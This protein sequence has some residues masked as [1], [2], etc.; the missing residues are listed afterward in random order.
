MSIKKKLANKFFFRYFELMEN[1]KAPAAEAPKPAAQTGPDRAERRRQERAQNEKPAPKPQAAQRQKVPEHVMKFI[2]AWCYNMSEANKAEYII[3]LAGD[4][5]NL[6]S[7][8]QVLIKER[9][10]NKSRIVRPH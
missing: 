6:A 9:K 1:N 8:V 5:A 7:M 4:V 10:E 2:N 3:R